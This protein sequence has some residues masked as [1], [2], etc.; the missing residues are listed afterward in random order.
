MHWVLRKSEM[1]LACRLGEWEFAID[2]NINKI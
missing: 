1:W 2:F